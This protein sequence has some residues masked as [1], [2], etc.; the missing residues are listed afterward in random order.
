MQKSSGVHYNPT[1]SMD[2]SGTTLGNTAVGKVAGYHSTAQKFTG[3]MHPDSTIFKNMP[4]GQSSLA[5]RN[6]KFT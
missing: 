1:T 5:S 3:T 4:H 6:L 2:P